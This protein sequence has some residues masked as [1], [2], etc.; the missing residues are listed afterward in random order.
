MLAGLIP[1]LRGTV[2]PALVVG[3]LSELA[4]TGV[5][6][7][8]ENGLYVKNGGRVCQIETD[9]RWLYLG[10]ASG[11]GFETVGNDVFLKTQGRLYDGRGRILGPNS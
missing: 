4:S 5:Q 6:E 10:P 11:K 2:L 3:E 9:G 7:L 1:F 8:I